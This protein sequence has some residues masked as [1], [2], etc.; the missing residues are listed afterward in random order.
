VGTPHLVLFG[1][2][3][4]P[5]LNKV[6]FVCPVTGGAPPSPTPPTLLGKWG[7]CAEGSGVP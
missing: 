4:D 5:A 6:Y 1:G 7:L 2:A 3:S